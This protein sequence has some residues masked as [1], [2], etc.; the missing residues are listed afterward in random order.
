MVFFEFLVVI[1]AAI[2]IG[3]LFYYLL[4][5]TGP[6]GSLWTIILILVFAGLA[7]AAWITP[8][9]PVAGRIA[10]LPVLFVILLFAIFLAAATPSSERSRYPGE[11]LPTEDTTGSPTYVTLSAFFWIFMLLLLFAAIAGFLR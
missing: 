1:L 8:V 11:K 2:A 5:Y 9:G 6:W 10:W 7:A 4:K 3:S